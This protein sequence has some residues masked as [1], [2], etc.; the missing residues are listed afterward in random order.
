MRQFLENYGSEFW[1]RLGEHLGLVLGSVLVSAVIG[2]SLGFLVWNQ[3]RSRSITLSI[4]NALQTIPGLAL[5]ALLLPVLGIGWL[6]TLVALVLYTMLPMLRNTITSFASVPL[7]LREVTRQL[8][9]TPAQV[10]WHLMI[11]QSAPFL[12][13]GL[14]TSF[15]WAV[16][17]ATLGAFIGA[18]G[19]GDF[20]N[21][22]IALNDM[23]LI[24]LG[25]I[26]AA[27]LALTFDG[28]LGRLEARAQ[29]WKEGR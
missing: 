5:L 21:R 4:C 27:G 18:G 25:A 24:L 7:E 15:V 23:R 13:S 2:F 8:G 26:P 1:L 9:F 17:L 19:L 29:L 16:S 14:R 28:V 10:W 22:G 3:P 12:V 20:I 11:P 6:P